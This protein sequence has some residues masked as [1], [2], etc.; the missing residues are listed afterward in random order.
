MD[1]KHLF[2]AL[3][4]WSAAAPAQE[5]EYASTPDAGRPAGPD[6]SKM[7]FTPTSIRMVVTHHQPQIQECYEEILAGKSDVVEGRVNTA[8]VITAEGL[9]RDPKIVKQG[10]TLKNA[11]LYDCVIAVLGTMT[12]PKPPKGREQ[13]VDYPFNLKA[14]R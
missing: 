12:F 2:A 10:T 7:P 4:L 13:P 14:I 1:V 3:L 9:V 5:A 8:W 6:V 11:Q